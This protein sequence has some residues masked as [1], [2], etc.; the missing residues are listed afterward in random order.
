MHMRHKLD[1]DTRLIKGLVLDHGA[2]HPDMPKRLEVCAGAC[3]GCAGAHR[4]VQ[5]RAGPRPAAAHDMIMT[6]TAG[7]GAARAAAAAASGVLHAA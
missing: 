7:S 5:G 1:Q 4:G 3:R 2:R 6:R